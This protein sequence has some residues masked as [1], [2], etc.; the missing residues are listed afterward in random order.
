[1]YVLS[2]KHPTS[3]VECAE[4]EG[5]SLKADL[6]ERISKFFPHSAEVPEPAL[7]LTWEGASEV[8]PVIELSPRPGSY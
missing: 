7:A 2:V 6:V 8:I 5:K 1:M 4:K 3:R